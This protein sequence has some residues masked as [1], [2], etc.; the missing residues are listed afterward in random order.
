M[1]FHL[2]HVL[3]VSCHGHLHRIC[4]LLFLNC[5]Y[6]V[7]VVLVLIGAGRIVEHTYVCMYLG[8]SAY[9]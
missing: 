5:S 9:C 4:T 8:S 7:V 6:I 1:I 3:P 2:G